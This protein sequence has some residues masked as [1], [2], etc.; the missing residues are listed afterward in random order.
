MSKQARKRRA[1]SCWGPKSDAL[2]VGVIAR[3]TV[4]TDA[5]TEN[6]GCGTKVPAAL[7]GPVPTVAATNLFF[8]ET[9]WVRADCCRH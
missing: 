2:E 5:A 3:G 9:S 4:P 1:I 7:R 6:R 8:T